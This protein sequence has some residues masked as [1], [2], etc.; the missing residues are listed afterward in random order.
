MPDLQS[1]SYISYSLWVCEMISFLDTS[2]ARASFIV[3]SMM[4]Y[5]YQAVSNPNNPPVSVRKKGVLSR[6]GNQ[7]GMPAIIL[8]N[9]DAPSI[10]IGINPKT[11]Q[12]YQ[13]TCLILR[14]E[15]A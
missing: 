14:P 12:R 9:C 15:M 11:S 3:S 13:G 1:K 4:G 2:N 5:I 7:A 8:G 10:P 6:I